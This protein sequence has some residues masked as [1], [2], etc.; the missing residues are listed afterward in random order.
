M[1]N[2]FTILKVLLFLSFFLN[3]NILSAQADDIEVTCPSDICGA[4]DDFGAT[5]DGV[6]TD[7]GAT[8][9]GQP[10]YEG[11]VGNV[12]YRIK[13]IS[14]VIIP[15]VL[16]IHRWEI[17]ALDGTLV[18][19]DSSISNTGSFP[20][21]NIDNVWTS[22]NNDYNPIPT[23]SILPVEFNY[24]KAHKK[25]EQVHLFWQTA[26]EI[27][28]E[29]FEVQQSNDNQNW[30]TL[31]FIVG[32][33]TSYEPQD[34]EF[35]DK[36]PISGINYYRLKQIDYDGN[37]TYSSVLSQELMNGQLEIYPNPVNGETVNLQ[38]PNSEYNN[39]QVEIYDNLGRLVLKSILA[40]GERQ[41]NISDLPIG[42]YTLSVIT[43]GQFYQERLVKK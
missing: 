9:N 1:K 2:I 29:G 24:F 38:F 40:Y 17:H 11:P 6:Y 35:I 34:Y 23:T 30:K 27:S 21:S 18:Y 16:I 4:D 39:T 37:Y 25:N 7:S 19:F 32:E 20:F 26:T 3:M 43:K 12:A 22:E 28:N 33:G 8:E 13:C 10:I 15:G 41:L 42:I 14:E 36:N 31:D 5:V